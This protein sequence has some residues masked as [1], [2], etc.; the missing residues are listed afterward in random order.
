MDVDVDPRGRR[1]RRRAPP[2]AAGRGATS[3]DRPRCTAKC[4]T[5]SRTGRPLT[6]AWSERAVERVYSGEAMQSVN[7]ASQPPL[8]EGKEKGRDLRAEDEADPLLEI[9]A[10]RAGAGGPCARRGRAA[11]ATSGWARAEPEH[12]VLHVAQLG[13]RP[14]Q[15]LPPRG[16]RAEQLL[17]H[18]LGAWPGPRRD[19][20]AGGPP[21]STRTS[22]PSAAP[23]SAVRSTEPRH[24]GDGGQGLSP[25]ARGCGW[26][27]DPPPSG[28]CW[29]RGGAPRALHPRGTSPRRRRAPRWTRTPPP[30]R[31]TSM[32]RAPASSAFS[33]SSLTTEAGRSTTSPAAI[34]S[35]SASLSTAMVGIRWNCLVVRATPARRDGARAR[36]VTAGGRHRADQRLRGAAPATP[37]RR[38]P[39]GQ[40]C[41]LLAPVR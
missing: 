13:V 17:H 25:E 32:D 39:G 15:E 2:P 19:R 29:W 21:A 26:R 1:A 35:I 20:R 18:H 38:A 36:K 40:R 34:W 12:H 24:R 41:L 11:E 31:R 4:S 6:K 22:V 14:T 37:A 3:G 30:S 8:L 28:A 7:P 9:A 5:R 16:H 10:A 27:G 33:A 23:C